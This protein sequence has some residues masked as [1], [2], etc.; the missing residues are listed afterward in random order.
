MIEK[1]FEIKQIGELRILELYLYGEIE[2]DY[3]DYWQGGI[4]KSTTSADYVRK[5][6]DE[7]GK[8][9]TVNVYINSIGGDV[10]EG[11]AIY[12]IL[13]RHPAV[14]NVYIDAFAYSIASV[15]V[16]AGDK[17]FMPSNTTMMIH[18]AMWWCYGNSEQLRKSADNLDVI[19]EAS[20]NSYLVKANGKIDKETLTTLLNAETY[21]TAE[22][23]LKYGFVDEIINPVKLADAID[24]VQQAQQKKNPNAKMAFEKI[25]SDYSPTRQKE[26]ESQQE[27]QT[28]DDWFASLF[29]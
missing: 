22:M 19:N 15:I 10:N 5:T 21:L 26:S 29:N 24:V 23:A 11:V 25:K 8:I 13:K 6:L 1:S 12:N 7:A 27:V 16:M 17:V 2:G 28:A 20:C 14:V 3:Y 18:N 4:V 9:D